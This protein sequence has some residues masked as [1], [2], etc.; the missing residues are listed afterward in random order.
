M[1]QLQDIAPAWVKEINSEQAKIVEFQEV[2]ATD[3]NT[4]KSEIRSD[5][6]FFQSGMYWTAGSLLLVIITALSLFGYLVNTFRSQ[7]MK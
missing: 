1:P 5:S 2:V 7:R 3:F 6:E 4:L